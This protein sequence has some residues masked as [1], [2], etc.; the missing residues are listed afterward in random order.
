MAADLVREI[1]SLNANIRNGWSE[2]Q[3]RIID[4]YIDNKKKFELVRLSRQTNSSQQ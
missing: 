1:T 3:M 4:E 2:T